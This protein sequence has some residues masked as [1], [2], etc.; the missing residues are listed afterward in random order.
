MDG[1]ESHA[2][3][4]G[5]TGVTAGRVLLSCAGVI[6]LALLVLGGF[7]FIDRP[8]PL[9]ARHL[10][11]DVAYATT[12]TPVPP[13]PDTEWTPVTLPGGP[14][15]SAEDADYHAAWFRF[16]IPSELLAHEGTLAF[17]Q[18][19]PLGNI[20]LYAGD[21]LIAS[22]GPMGRPLPFHT[23]QLLMPF[24]PAVAR[25]Q[26]DGTLTFRFARRFA[27]P[28]SP[29]AYAGPV[30]VFQERFAHVRLWG[31]YIPF[32]IVAFMLSL[33]LLLMFLWVLRRRETAFGL[34]GL[35][36][37]LWAFHTAHGLIARPPTGHLPWYALDYLSL[38]W[39]VL[40]PVFV[41]R[42]YAMHRPRVERVMLSAA[43]LAS[44]VML[45][46]VAS[47]NFDLLATYANGVWLPLTQ[48]CATYALVLFA[49]AAWRRGD[50]E[51]MT[52]FVV[53]GLIFLVGLRDIV[54]LLGGPVP[55]QT[56]YL[57]YVAAIQ[58]LIIALLL[59]R[60]FT[61]S[62]RQTESMNVLLEQRVAEK[63]EQLE[64]FYRRLARLERASALERERA[65]LMRDVHDGI[66]GQLVQALA[67]SERDRTS[68]ELR[69]VLD[70][71]LL[72]LRMIIDS[73]GYDDKLETLLAV[74]R[75]RLQPTLVHRG[76]ALDWQIDDLPKVDLAGE[77]GLAVLRLVQEAVTNVLRHSDAS[78]LTVRAC[79]VDDDAILVQVRDNGRGFDVAAASS[80]HGLANMRARAA[81]T[82]G[83]LK[84]TSN[85]GGT[86]VS[87]IL[88]GSIDDDDALATS[89]VGV[90][91]HSDGNGHHD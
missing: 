3:N 12:D 28:R 9:P 5:E 80:G 77:R 86:T 79:K 56:F 45:I 31:F 35:I 27:S 54:F 57:Q 21:R 73:L 36:V 19:A 51:S 11:Q 41:H 64:R 14:T 71:A 82:G 42:W 67:L 78:R 44:A 26:A 13:G 59:A 68:G 85:D 90:A 7:Y 10:L 38:W 33:A 20:Q 53:A 50:F 72:D 55:G 23:R 37:G 43:V 15:R 46:P 1:G 8:I 52:L 47:G 70:A 69:E 6:G 61:A 17:Y 34:Y 91:W 75:Q 84:I 25:S 83:T 76:I 18:F 30:E 4:A 74:L 29:I 66:G 81:Q 65:R 87:L 49:I 88:P 58:M 63:S 48:A 24:D 60:R 89:P 22:G 2:G 62:L 39:A 16:R 32:A 40:M